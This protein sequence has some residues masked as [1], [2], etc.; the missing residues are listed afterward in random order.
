MN[1]R[2]LKE[3]VFFG[4]PFAPPDKEALE[5]MLR[6][7]ETDGMPKITFPRQT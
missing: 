7:S 4:G 6:E 5:Q 3:R 1:A 2:S